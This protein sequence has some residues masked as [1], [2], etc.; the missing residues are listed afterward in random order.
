MSW[1]TP[2]TNWSANYDSSGA[3]TGDYFEYTDYDR[4][5]SNIEFL[6]DWSIKLFNKYDISPMETV[7][8]GQFSYAYLFDYI[9]NNLK[10]IV[11]N[12]WPVGTGVYK[13]WAENSLTPTFEDFNRIENLCLDLY[14]LYEQI[15]NNLP[16]V[17][18]K[19]GVKVL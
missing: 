15:E 3:Y 14:N 16:K 7:V 2:K 18:F 6:Y 4:I 9:E 17:P 1:T 19:M 8:L 13:T 10:D 12:S 11:E 5:K